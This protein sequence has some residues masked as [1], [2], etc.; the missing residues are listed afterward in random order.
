MPPHNLTGFG[1]KN[2][3]NTT[4]ADF[5]IY[6]EPNDYDD[7]EVD[8]VSNNIDKDSTKNKLTLYKSNSI[9]SKQVNNI[10]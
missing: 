5:K 1:N 7:E 8:T 9:H 6:V 2:I 10:L 4:A 3:G